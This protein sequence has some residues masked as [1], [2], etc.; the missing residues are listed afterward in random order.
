MSE[1][2]RAQSQLRPVTNIIVAKMVHRRREHSKFKLRLMCRVAAGAAQ[3]PMYRYFELPNFVP[4]SAPR[5]QRTLLVHQP[6]HQQ[7][8]T[9]TLKSYKPKICPPIGHRSIQVQDMTDY[10]N[11]IDLKLMKPT[12]GKTALVKTRS[13]ELRANDK[14][15]WILAY[16]KLQSVGRPTQDESWTLVG[17]TECRKLRWTNIVE[18]P[19]QPVLAE[20]ACS[21][22]NWFKLEHGQLRP[23]HKVATPDQSTSTFAG[24]RVKF[25]DEDAHVTQHAQERE[26]IR[27]DLHPASS[28]VMMKAKVYAKLTMIQAF[29]AEHD[30]YRSELPT[31]EETHQNLSWNHGIY[32]AYHGQGAMGGSWANQGIRNVDY[33]DREQGPYLQIIIQTTLNMNADTRKMRDRCGIRESANRRLRRHCSLTHGKR[34]QQVSPELSDRWGEGLPTNSWNENPLYSWNT[35]VEEAPSARPGSNAGIGAFHFGDTD[36]WMDGPTSQEP[37]K[38]HWSARIVMDLPLET[39]T[40]SGNKRFRGIHCMRSE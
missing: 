8:K 3:P 1:V 15:Y 2:A 9:H 13:I 16:R 17:E 20:I 40:I 24:Y 25:D 18:A 4:I 38:Y 10:D 27:T 14:K 39:G 35:S 31:D 19:S 6:S 30:I 11:A 29:G 34:K 28:I 7:L 22:P 33:G 32:D 26:Q 37:H 5:P 36:G 12:P 23:N 21:N